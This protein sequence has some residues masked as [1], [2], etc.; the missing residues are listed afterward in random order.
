LGMPGMPWHAQKFYLRRPRA[1][2][3]EA[4]E[5]GFPPCVA[6]SA[7]KTGVF[8]KPLADYLR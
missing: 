4:R 5:G 3:I 8:F 2:S 7:S 6:S 1:R